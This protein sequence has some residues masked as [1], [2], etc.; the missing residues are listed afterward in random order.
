MPFDH[1]AAAAVVKYAQPERSKESGGGG[2]GTS[3]DC[4]RAS[5]RKTRALIRSPP[6][7]PIF[8]LAFE[9]I[10]RSGRRI[11]GSHSPGE[12]RICGMVKIWGALHRHS[13]L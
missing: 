1:A 13:G 3:G 11:V 12:S 6:E 8:A 10:D 9:P 4:R 7:V 5:R 2:P